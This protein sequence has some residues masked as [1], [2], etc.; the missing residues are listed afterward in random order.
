MAASEVVRWSSVVGE[1]GVLLT[2]MGSMEDLR[3]PIKPYPRI[4]VCSV[5]HIFLFQVNNEGDK[6][7]HAHCNTGFPHVVDRIQRDYRETSSR[8]RG[9]FKT[10]GS[11]NMIS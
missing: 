7:V 10:I 3:T 1:Y 9:N 8:G 11:S 4:K 2:E 6:L 5:I